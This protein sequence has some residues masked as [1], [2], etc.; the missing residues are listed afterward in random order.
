MTRDN[1]VLQAAVRY[2][3]HGWPVFPLAAGTKVPLAR[4]DGLLEATTDERQI[5][6]W[7]ERYPHRN[8]AV[9]TGRPGPDV[10]D[11]DTAKSGR[12]AGFAGFNQARRA[13]LTG[14]P[15]AII[16][17]PSG[18]WHAYYRGTGQRSGKLRE[19][20]IDFRS[21]GGY[22]A[23]VPSAVGGRAYQVMKVQR[24]ADTCDFSK[25][26]DLLEPAPERSPWQ[27]ATD[28]R[29]VGHLA[30]WVAGLREGNRD[31]GTWWAMWRAFQAGDAGTVTEIGRAALSVGLSQRDVDRI[32]R[33]AEHIAAHPKAAGR[34]RE[35]G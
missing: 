15:Q 32:T 14:T 1:P 25:I 24:S 9:A 23:T 5:A 27:P 30:E 10:L 28:G 26:R 31:D 20:G 7:F 13:G 3:E 2:A 12:P 35:A 4:S 18:G 22:V 8:L 6:G 33:S 34:G 11:M 29:G 19:H 16:T 21:Q 17:T